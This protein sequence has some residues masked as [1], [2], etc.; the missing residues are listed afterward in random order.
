VSENAPEPTVVQTAFFVTVGMDGVISVHTQEIPSVRMTREATLYDIETYG[1]Q[2]VRNV[3]RVIATQ[4]TL[5]AVLPT[6]EPT[7][8]E[9]V[10]EALKKREGED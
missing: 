2:L 4:M 7:S 9:R 10:A 1:S 8:A 5:A 6:P 3:S